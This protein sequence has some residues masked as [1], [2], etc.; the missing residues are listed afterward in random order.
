VNTDLQLEIPGSRLRPL[1][2]GNFVLRRG[3]WILVC[4]G[5][6]FALGSP[7]A[8]LLSKPYYRASGRL[9]LTQK[10]KMFLDR[11][12][13]IIQG[14]FRDFAATYAERLSGP[15]VARRA[16]EATPRE[17]WPEF[18]RGIPDPK[19]AAQVLAARLAVIPI[20]RSHLMEVALT[21]G[22]ASGMAETINAV[23]KTFL[24]LLHE[25]Q[26]QD[27]DRRLAY[28][29]QELQDLRSSL[30]GVET[31][32][33]TVE[34]E[35]G[36]GSFSE[37]RNPFYELLIAVQSEHQRALASYFEEES[38]A[39][40]TAKEQEVLGERDLG[41]FAEEAVFYNESVYLIDNWTYQKLQDLRTGIDGLTEDNPDRI[42]VEERMR[43]MNEYL[44]R[45]KKDLHAT[46]LGLLERK[47]AFEL[48][49]AVAK[50]QAALDA[51]EEFEERLKSQLDEAREKFARSSALVNRGKELSE[52]MGRL[53]ERIG[54][55]QDRIREV[56]LEA[57]LPV[58][59]G[60]DELAEAPASPE[61]DNLGKLLAMIFVGAFGSV[62]SA[63]LAYE[64]L[65]GRIRSA[66]DIRA[67]LGAL[68]ADPVPAGPAERIQSALRGLA[69][70]LE[71]ER[72]R[73][74][75]RIV[76][77]CG[78]ERGS[79]ASW[80]AARLAG[81][82]T[83]YADRILVVRLDEPESSETAP[84]GWFGYDFETW[85]EDGRRQLLRVPERVTLLPLGDESPLLSRRDWLR[86][87][88][89]RVTA[90]Y[91]MV[92]VDA[93]PLPESDLSRY[94]AGISQIGVLVARQGHSHFGA[95][96]KGVELAVRLR[97]PALTG[98]LIGKT[99]QPL[100]RLLAIAPQLVE[101]RLPHWMART[102]RTLSEKAEGLLVRAGR[103][104]GREP[105]KGERA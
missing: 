29:E 74:G 89:E 19:V 28:L 18:V 77:V 52:E 33:R 43:A 31:S 30:A 75:A 66:A 76:L 72:K 78:A 47:R 22:E 45:F 82:M 12:E 51:R 23:M 61:G 42:Y 15:A 21:S 1:D 65:D 102:R 40:Q 5:L 46:A 16:L 7:L 41:I 85:F 58:H 3:L 48:S 55:V 91:D 104:L 83:Q 79:G 35:L 56:E 53:K 38:K 98:V 67:A 70:R 84:G 26:A 60:I 49:E 69:L 57:K 68:P 36:H 13:Q 4:G 37:E 73:T 86:M 97:L 92:L 90:D 93:R 27:S 88:L 99:E 50:A 101:R 100:E 81:A 34:G 11:Q 2:P 10:V 105:W 44:E 96:R 71:A 8:F 63:L 87:F 17:Q 54:R 103:S 20:G 24:E 32:R 39:G 95:F 25:E 64:F 80:T 94:V 59:V 62:G 14:D 6:L 9:L